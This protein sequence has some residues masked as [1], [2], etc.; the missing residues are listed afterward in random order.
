MFMCMCSGLQV[1]G[2][3]LLAIEGS[4]LLHNSGGTVSCSPVCHLSPSRS[5]P[6]R[7]K[8]VLLSL[9][10]SLSCTLTFQ[11][12]F[13]ENHVSLPAVN[14]TDE[15][16]HLLSALHQQRLPYDIHLSWNML[17]ICYSKKQQKLVNMMHCPL[18]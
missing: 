16:L 6:P 15:H 7:F 5:P 12:P 17:K 18:N 9:F 10:L 3:G 2:G 14:V 11:A 13:E 8:T 4:L 1:L